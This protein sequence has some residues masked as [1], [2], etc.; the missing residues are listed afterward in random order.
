MLDANIDR[1]IG[2]FS[3]P[4]GKATNDEAAAAVNEQ[5]GKLYT[6]IRVDDVRRSVSFF[7]STAGEGGW[8]GAP[9][10][11]AARHRTGPPSPD[12]SARWPS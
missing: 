11:R 12:R 2:Q 5:T 1:W 4:D 10:Q 6:V 9:G 7:G 8:R 3:Q